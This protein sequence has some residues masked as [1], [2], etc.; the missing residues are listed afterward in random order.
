MYIYIL[1]KKIQMHM[2]T[3]IFVKNGIIHYILI[4]CLFPLIYC[5]YISN[6]SYSLL[7]NFYRLCSIL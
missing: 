2:Y 5:K 1:Y 3:Y 6:S 4:C 7:Y